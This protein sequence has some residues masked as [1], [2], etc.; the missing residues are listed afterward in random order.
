[1]SYDYAR[2][3]LK[4]IYPLEGV[5]I[6]L[7]CGRTYSFSDKE[8]TV[9]K[10]AHWM[11]NL[12]MGLQGS[13]KKRFCPG[14]RGRRDKNGWWWPLPNEGCDAWLSHWEEGKKPDPWIL[15]KHCRSFQHTEYLVKHRIEYLVDTTFNGIEPGV[16][17][18]LLRCLVIGVPDARPSSRLMLHWLIAQFYDD[19]VA[20]KFKDPENH[21]VL[22]TR[23]DLLKTPDGGV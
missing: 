12:N 4:S 9:V 19:Y 23:F 5:D 15:W 10:L 16:I 11:R 2:E 22:N 1:L 18:Y 6:S 3:F 17:A 13:I 8:R 20:G 7:E 21:F 14:P